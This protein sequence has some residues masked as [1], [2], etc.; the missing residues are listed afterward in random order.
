VG[1]GVLWNGIAFVAEH[2]YAFDKLRNLSLS[3]FMAVLYIAAALGSGPLVRAVE[4]RLSARS[5]L[6]I[7]LVLLAA[8]CGAIIS[9]NAEWMLW[10]VAA[11]TSALAAT[12]WPIIESYVTAGRHGREM[13]TTIGWWNVTWTLAVGLGLVGMAP[14]MRGDPGTARYAIVTLGALYGVAALVLPFIPARPAAH[15]EELSRAHVGAEYR[16]LLLS[17]RW[18]LPLSYLLVGAL[19]PLLPYVLD[20]LRIDDG[21]K[22]PLAATW[23]F[24]RV[25]AI[26]IMWRM[27]GWH[28]RWGTLLAAGAGLALGFAAIVAAP[29]LAIILVA[30]VLFGA[31]QGATYYAALYYAMS[32]G[33]AEVEAGGV[34]EA[35]IG[36][37]YAAGPAAGMLGLLF[38]RETERL[39]EDQSV[40]AI[41][42][43]AVFLAS[44]FMLRHYLAARKVRTRKSGPA[45]G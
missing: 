1:T 38:A 45:T 31:A 43:V 42:F 4:R 37:G 3:L 12:L 33:K 25:G 20:D 30:L 14:F 18:L 35:L 27:P 15:D 39:N 7:L 44:P 2:G 36:A 21:W 29:S 32:V 40:I 16:R 10:V 8:T 5:I 26:A 24:A 11:L 17:A 9:A 6:L 34:H 23:M 41:A 22:T 28:G 13:R 19:S